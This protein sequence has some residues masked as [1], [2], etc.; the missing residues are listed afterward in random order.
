VKLLAGPMTAQEAEKM[1]PAFSNDPYWQK[2]KAAFPAGGQ[3]WKYQ[4]VEQP[5]QAGER[6]YAEG[7]FAALTADGCLIA[8]FIEW[9]T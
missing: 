4:L 8:R 7:G 2:F 6:G 5:R 3:I 9:L 1:N